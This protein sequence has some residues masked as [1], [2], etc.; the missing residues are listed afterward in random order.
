MA[1]AAS[2]S[3]QQ[4]HP[5]LHPSLHQQQHSPKHSAELL[6]SP[7]DVQAAE[8]V[9]VVI[10]QMP[11]RMSVSDAQ[12]LARAL[13][14]AATG[15]I[16]RPSSAE[17]QRRAHTRIIVPTTQPLSPDRSHTET[18]ALEYSA[19]SKQL[20]AGCGDGSLRIFGASEG[21]AGH[22]L[23]S[24]LQHA[25]DGEHLPATCVRYSPAVSFSGAEANGARQLAAAYADGNVCQWR[26]SREG[27]SGT[28]LRSVGSSA[29]NSIY[30]LAFQSDG[31]HFAAAGRDHAVRL[32]DATTGELVRSFEKDGVHGHSNR[33]YALRF[34]ST[35]A[36]VLLS[37]GWDNTVQM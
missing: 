29:G 7:A 28:K 11:R 24:V 19:D 4:P 15:S 20:A 37:G 5:H 17:A 31:L 23:L 33:V 6:S 27:D 36:H 16:S 21:I 14:Q 1:A 3:S 25:E 2:S 22:R 30:T 26:V 12:L 32:Y 9:N 8:P 34:H 10:P 35:E 18:F 13:S